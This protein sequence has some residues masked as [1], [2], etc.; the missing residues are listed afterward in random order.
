[1]DY[2]GASSGQFYT[3]WRISNY[4][5]VHQKAFEPVALDELDESLFVKRYETKYLFSPELLDSI[6]NGLTDCYRIVSI[7]N[8]FLQAYETLYFDTPSFKFYLDHQ[9]GKLN[10]YKVRFRK[11]PASES[12]YIEIKFKN[13]KNQTEKWREEITNKKYSNGVITEEENRF[14]TT[15][16]KTHP[17]DLTPRLAIAYSRLAFVHRS[18]GE[19]VTIDLDLSYSKGYDEKRF[20][21]FSIAEVKR[22]TPSRDSS[23]F[24]IMRELH[25]PPIRFSKYCFGIYQFYPL[26]KYNRFKPRYMFLQ[27]ISDDNIPYQEYESD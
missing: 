16:F 27:R 12:M 11:Y 21:N 22:E 24:Q 3:G 5:N 6:L 15:Y 10:R 17:G 9:N 25:I 18:N 20:N 13:N 19:R 26:L 23:F 14:I 2:S 4:K 8:H 7:N 1:M